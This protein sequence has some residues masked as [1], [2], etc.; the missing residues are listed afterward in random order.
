MNSKSQHGYATLAIGVVLLFMVSLMSIYLTR[1]GLIDLRTSAN[2]VRYTEALAQAEERLETVLAW[3]SIGSNRNT[4]NVAS[5][6]NCSDASSPFDSIS[7]TDWQCLQFS[8]GTVN[9]LNQ[10][11]FTLLIPTSQPDG[12]IYYIATNGQSADGSGNAQVM[13]GVYFY[14]ANEDGDP[15][16]PPM[17]GAGN[18]PLNGTFSVVPNPNGGGRGIPV[19]VWSRVN[20]DAPQGSSATCQIQEF[21]ANGDCSTSPISYKDFKGPDIVDNDPSFPSDVFQYIFGVPSAS[22]GTIKSQ[23]QKVSNCNSLSGMTGIVWVTGSCTI[24]AGTTV[25]PNLWVVVE[26]GDF[27]MNA[28]SKFKGLLFAFGPPQYDGDGNLI[29]DGG[30]KPIYNAGSITANG[31]AQFFGSM[32]SNDTTTMGI[33]INGTFDMIYSDSDIGTG[34]GPGETLFKPMARIPGSWSDYLPD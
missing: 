31:G 19:S 23:A 30:G 24:A 3:M 20:I 25:G 18:V 1:S 22:Y 28:N 7:D 27:Q 4:I 5:F 26:G 12:S 9:G 11:D 10:N 34:S 8:S 32:I 16:F 29:V 2:K 33:N 15:T 14:T 13:Q 6:A 21:N 17:M